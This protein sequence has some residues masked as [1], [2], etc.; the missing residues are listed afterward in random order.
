MAKQNSL[1]LFLG[2]QYKF[3]TIKLKPKLNQ[4]FTLV[5]AVVGMI[6]FLVA[7]TAIVPIFM[8]YKIATLTNDS[9]VGA[10]ALAQQIMDTLRSTDINTLDTSNRLLT[11]S[12]Y[13][14]GAPIVGGQSLSSL[15][16][17]GKTYSA[18][19]TYCTTTSYC[20]DSSKHIIVSVYGNGNNS[21]PLFALETVYA[22]LQ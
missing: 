3:M 5:E 4:G 12:V 20:S 1:K 8:T 17:K 2:G 11:E 6:I 19:I 14:S 22:R 10:V 15:S 21:T 16:Y 7:S 9:R 13:P 18:T